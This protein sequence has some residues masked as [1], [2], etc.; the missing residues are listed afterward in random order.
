MSVKIDKIL[1][2]NK[3]SD[4]LTKPATLSYWQ[5]FPMKQYYDQLQG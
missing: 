5:W 2:L 3:V 4:M 1:L